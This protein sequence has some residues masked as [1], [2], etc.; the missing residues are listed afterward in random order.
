MWVCHFYQFLYISIQILFILLSFSFQFQLSIYLP[1]QKK[2][3]NQSKT[4]T[5]FNSLICFD[6]IICH[7]IC[8]GIFFILYYYFQCSIFSTIFSI[9]IITKI[10]ILQSIQTLLIN[11]LPACRKTYFAPHLLIED[12]SQVLNFH[13]P[14]VVTLYLWSWC[15]HHQ[16][17]LLY[18]CMCC[19]Q[20]ET[21]SLLQIDELHIGCRAT[22]MLLLARNLHSCC[23]YCL[24]PGQINSSRCASGS[25]WVPVS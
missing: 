17:S 6:I 15:L 16:A 22:L 11:K 8:Y 25:L 20:A 14:S 1:R 4:T 7:H 12:P 24:P 2:K 18:G 3:N 13:H 5:V 23:L 9:K 10:F 21:V 19:L